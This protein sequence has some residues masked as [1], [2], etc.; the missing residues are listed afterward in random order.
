MNDIDDSSGNSDIGGS[1]DTT[2]INSSDSTAS[3]SYDSASSFHINIPHFKKS[4]VLLLTLQTSLQLNISS[5]YGK[6]N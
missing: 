1:N 3:C 4:L 6:M 5:F 2:A